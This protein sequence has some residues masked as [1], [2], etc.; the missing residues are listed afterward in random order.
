MIGFITAVFFMFRYNDH[1]RFV[2]QRL[3][4]LAAFLTYLRNESLITLTEL[5]NL[6]GGL[7]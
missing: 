7:L 6:L 1:W 4:F 2:I 3:S 5:A